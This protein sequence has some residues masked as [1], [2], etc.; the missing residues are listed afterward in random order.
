MVGD[1]APPVGR[2]EIGADGGRRHQQMG[3]VGVAAEGVDVGVLEEQQVLF[4]AAVEG[5]L[6]GQGLLVGD[7]A[8]PAGPQHVGH[9]SSASQSR[10]SMIV[11]MVWRNLEA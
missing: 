10:V 3:R 7:P 9:A 2:L 5:A 4:V 8:Q 6:E 11:R 1:V